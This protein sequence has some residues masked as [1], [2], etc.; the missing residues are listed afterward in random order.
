MASSE[1]LFG[2]LVAF[3]IFDPQCCIDD[4]GDGQSRVKPR[5]CPLL[6]HQST[7]L[8]WTKHFSALKA[9]GVALAL[10]APWG[11]ALRLSTWS[12]DVWR[13]L[14]E[15]L[16]FPAQP[17]SEEVRIG[18]VRTATVSQ[19]RLFPS[20]HGLEQGLAERFAAF[21]GRAPRFVV[22]KTSAD[23]RAALAA[24]DIDIAAVGFSS[25]ASPTLAALAV[26][27]TDNPWLIAYAPGVARPRGDRDLDGETVL[28][29]PR[30]AASRMYPEVKARFPTTRFVMASE[31]DEEALLAQ[32]DSGQVRLALVDQQSVEALQHVYYG[33]G[34]GLTVHYAQRAWLVKAENADLVNDIVHFAQVAEHDRSMLAFRDQYFGHTRAVNSFDAMVFEQR[35]EEVLPKWRERLKRAQDEHALDWRLLAALAYQESHWQPQAVSATGVWGF[36]QLTQDTAN[37]YGVDRTDPDAA[38]AAG[39]KHLA[40]LH[41]ATPE[42]IPEPD[43]TYLALAAYNIGLGH[44]EDARILAQRAKTNPDRWVDVKAQLPR[45]ADPSVAA[46]LKYG[47]ARGHEAVEYVDRIRAFYDIIARHEGE[48]VARPKTKRVTTRRPPGV[49]E[50]KVTEPPVRTAMVSDSVALAARPGR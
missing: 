28:V 40:Y 38:I 4:I 42:R 6:T 24:G 26:E 7:P 41:R 13:P 22:F 27:S 29:L 34:T 37:M 43:R 1:H 46:T 47:L 39:A 15:A 48:H 36:M 2:A 45:L 16:A 10:A 14:A 49:Q 19:P 12:A 33:V 50:V 30:I 8:R 25:D 11:A 18:V 44:V 20:I 21:T 32:V 5:Q 31:D 23:A 17:L 9:L 3:R 35:I